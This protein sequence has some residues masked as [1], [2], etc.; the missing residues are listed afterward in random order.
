VDL[1]PGTLATTQFTICSLLASYLKRKDLKV[2]NYNVTYM[3]V[4]TDFSAQEMKTDCT[5]RV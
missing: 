5:P 3:S 2:Q 1:I 4:K